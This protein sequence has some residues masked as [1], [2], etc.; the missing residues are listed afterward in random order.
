MAEAGDL[1]MVDVAVHA[2]AEITATNGKTRPNANTYHDLTNKEW[3]EHTS[4]IT[5]M[6]Q[7]AAIAHTECTPQ[8]WALLKTLLARFG[9]HTEKL[10][11]ENDRLKHKLQQGDKSKYIKS[12]K[13]SWAAVAA[14]A[15]GWS[16]AN[17]QEISKTSRKAKEITI[18]F[19]DDKDREH[20]SKLIA[21]Q[22]QDKL[23]GTG[24]PDVVAIRQ[25]SS[26]D[27]AVH[28]STVA[29]AK[30]KTEDDGWARV[31]GPSARVV[32]KTYSVI[33]HGI[34]KDVYKQE[35]QKDY[36]ERLQLH[37]TNLH[38]DLKIVRFSWPSWTERPREDG[39][40][41]IYTSMVVETA[42]PDMANKI[43]RDGFVE[44]SEMKT[45]EYYDKNGMIL[46]CF[47]CE[48]YSSIKTIEW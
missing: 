40:K 12:D 38:P 45:C 5:E 9:H 11:G 1:A 33:V 21:K 16:P 44:N 14:A 34:R 15:N 26:K 7:I 48:Q 20:V 46:Q 25:L 2:E 32:K 13:Y 17:A 37:N 19:G 3:T 42:T 22:I 29:A 27:I 4:L 18:T 36:I 30:A 41:R 47:R 39:T 35:D 10:H 28:L 31:L 24:S 6:M 8:I 43:L 23:N